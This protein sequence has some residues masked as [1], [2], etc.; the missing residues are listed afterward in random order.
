MA[1]SRVDTPQQHL[2]VWDGDCGLCQAAIEWVHRH[3]R[4]HS[5][6]TASWQDCDDSRLTDELRHRCFKAVHVITND[7]SVYGAARAVLFILHDLYGFRL[8]RLAE[9]PP[10]IWLGELVYRLIANN[11]KI[12]G[13]L[14]THLHLIPAGSTCVTATRVT[15]PRE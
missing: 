3:D 10:F 11:R 12:I 5:F 2:I 6:A 13:R 7:N 4:R 15:I 14:A 1:I 8:L 9:K